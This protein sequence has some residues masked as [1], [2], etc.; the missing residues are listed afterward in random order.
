VII[1]LEEITFVG[2]F[3]LGIVTCLSPCS[4]GIIFSFLTYVV[5]TSKTVRRG[6]FTGLAFILGLSIIFFIIGFAVTFVGVIAR[7]YRI[8]Y[9]IAGVLFVLFGLNNLG[10]FMKIKT[11]KIK[12]IFPVTEGLESFKLSALNK[13]SKY[14]YLIG[15]FALGVVL[16]LAWAP[17]S[18]SLIFPVIIMVMA[19]AATPLYGGTLLFTFGLGH[20][21]PI[22][23]ISM[24]FVGVREVISR[25]FILASM[26]V[27]KIFGII[28]IGL[29]VWMFSYFFNIL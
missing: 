28:L 12:N 2:L 1:L 17:C 5:G 11:P 21:V 20:G 9:G 26:W 19:Q 7:H 27:R 16:G 4:I 25:K 24:V 23:L 15:S 18:I 6:L 29:S 8:F 13:F 14:H 3:T 22:I 10:A